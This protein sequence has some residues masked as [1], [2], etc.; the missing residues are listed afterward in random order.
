[1]Q[2]L[3]QV[4]VRNG[5]AKLPVGTDFTRRGFLKTAGAGLLA[6]KMVSAGSSH[7]ISR[8]SEISADFAPS[9]GLTQISPNLCILRDTCNVYGLKSADHALLIDFGLSHILKLFKELFSSDP[10]FGDQPITNQ[11]VHCSN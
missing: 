7:G 8:I 2:T 9:G 4:E 10:L 1:L 3:Q 5:K 11:E 6:P